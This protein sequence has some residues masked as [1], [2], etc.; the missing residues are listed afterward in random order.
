MSRR[1]RV[2][3]PASPPTRSLP[4][5]LA[6]LLANVPFGRALVTRGAVLIAAYVTTSAVVLVSAVG[7]GRMTTPTILA[8]VLSVFFISI[9]SGGLEPGTSKALIVQGLG[10]SPTRQQYRGI[11]LASGVKALLASVPLAALWLISDKSLSIGLLASL[12]F[13][14]LAGFLTTDFRVLLDA[15]GRYASAIWFKQSGM[16]ISFGTLAGLVALGLGLEWA[17]AYSTLVRLGW[18]GAALAWCYALA[19]FDAKFATPPLDYAARLLKQRSWVHF[20]LV[21]ALATLSGSLDRVA[22]LRLLSP[23][24]YNAYFVIYEVVTKLWLLP[25]LIAPILFAKRASG[26]VDK[27]LLIVMHLI[28]GVA[29]LSFAT[30]VVVT[31]A[32]MPNL[33]QFVTGLSQVPI[34]PLAAFALAI[35]ISSFCQLVLVDLQARGGARSATILT[36]VSLASAVV[37]FYSLTYQLG[38]GGLLLAWLLKSSLELIISIGVL[39]RAVDT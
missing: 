34:I 21:S 38:L 10:A 20:A 9:L 12:P 8:G 5:Q 25:Y 33:F 24:D 3:I 26:N 1:K 17:V 7:L 30:A 14:V 2:G 22:A 23:A 39:R 18:T 13:I 27:H 36:L 15:Q 35:V 16:I 11:A 37:M 32:L 6:A 29:G 28:V 4:P 19:P 31:A